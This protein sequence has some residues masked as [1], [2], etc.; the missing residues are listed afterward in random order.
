MKIITCPT[1]VTNLVNNFIFWLSNVLM[2]IYSPN[3]GKTYTLNLI[4]SADVM[5][6]KP[7]FNTILNGALEKCGTIWSQHAT[8]QNFRNAVK[9]VRKFFNLR[10][11]Q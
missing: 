3:R 8:S 2:Q 9:K 4:A 1:N 11:S 10:R 6:A 5:K 7:G